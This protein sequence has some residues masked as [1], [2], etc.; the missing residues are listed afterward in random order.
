MNENN[1]VVKFV[2]KKDDGQID[3]YTYYYET[4][5]LI[6]E[7]AECFVGIRQTKEEVIELFEKYMRA[8][9]ISCEEVKGE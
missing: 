8:E 6:N 4:K 2:V 5:R 1:S 3:K 9:I 7:T